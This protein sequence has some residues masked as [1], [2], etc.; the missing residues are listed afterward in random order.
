MRLRRGRCR[1]HSGRLAQTRLRQPVELGQPVSQHRLG[2]GLG[3]LLAVE[4]EAQLERL[5]PAADHQGERQLHLLHH[6][7]KARHQLVGFGGDRGRR[8]RVVLEHEQT[9]EQTR[10][11]FGQ[12]RQ[13]LGAVLIERHQVGLQLGDML[14]QGQL[15]APRQRQ[16]Q[17]VD[18]EPDARG[19]PLDGV[20]PARGHVAHQGDGIARAACQQTVPG[21][22]GQ[23]ARGHAKVAGTAREQGCHL[24]RQRRGAHRRSQL[25]MAPA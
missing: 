14:G 19:D 25:G 8:H 15:G 22:L 3:D 20:I 18:V 12:C 11:A 9:L 21:I 24:G 7:A 2:P 23:Q 6:G 4:F 5:A 17:A 1:R 10:P 16:R 13:R